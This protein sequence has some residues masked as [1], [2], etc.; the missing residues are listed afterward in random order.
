MEDPGIPGPES[1]PGLIKAAFADNDGQPWVEVVYGTSV[2]SNRR[3]TQFF[4][5][6]KVS[7]MDACNLKYATRFCFDRCM[8]LPWS[9]EYFVPLPNAP[10]PI[11]GHLTP[12]SI[13]ILQVQ[14]SYYQRDKQSRDG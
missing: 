7:E 6:S 14:M 9:E 8:Q 10:T 12:Y 5:I 1:H 2:D 11:V 4:T 13:Q 3:G